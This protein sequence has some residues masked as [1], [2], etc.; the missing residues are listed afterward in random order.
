MQLGRLAILASLGLISLVQAYFL[1]INIPYSLT[2][3]LVRLWE[4]SKVGQGYE[5]PFQMKG[6]AWLSGRIQMD[7][8]I[9]GPNS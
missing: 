1:S 5:G 4:F 7:E 3:A 6:Y 2:R 9:M 8:A